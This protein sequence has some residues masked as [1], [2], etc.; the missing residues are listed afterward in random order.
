MGLLLR[1]VGGN[2]QRE[3]FFSSALHRLS[4]MKYAVGI[5]RLV[6]ALLCLTWTSIAWGE[7]SD[8][9]YFTY[10]TNFLL[11]LVML[12]AGIACL[13]DGKQPPAWLKGVLTLYIIITGLVAIFL[14]PPADSD[15]IKYVFGIETGNILHWTTPILAVLDFIFFDAHRRFKWSY[16]LTWL[17]YFPFYLAF[18]LIRA[19]L[20]PHSGPEKGGNPYPY[21]FIDVSRIGWGQMGV[22]IAFCIVGFAILGLILVVVDHILPKKPLI[23]SVRR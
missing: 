23:G 3:R 10:E 16:T 2:A 20:W 4:D 17:I 21:G 9:V 19:Q 18:V 1:Q 22:N 6:I 7:P 12:W 5:Y 15:T 11:G 13:I 8:W 14:L